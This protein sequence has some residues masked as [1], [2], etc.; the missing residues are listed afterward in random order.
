M[1]ES[2]TPEE[3]LSWTHRDVHVANEWGI[4]GGTG[5]C[6]VCALV[7]AGTAIAADHAST[8]ICNKCLL[9][10]IAPKLLAR[11]DELLAAVPPTPEEE[12]SEMVGELAPEDILKL[13]DFLRRMQA[14]AQAQGEAD[15]ADAERETNDGGTETQH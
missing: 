9:P 7:Q 3:G 2:E 4:Q 15:A 6:G 8:F 10:R 13:V 14:K 1:S 5:R 11:M 12:L